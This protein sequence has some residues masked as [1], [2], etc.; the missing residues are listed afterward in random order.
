[1][2]S[3]IENVKI[4]IQMLLIGA[5]LLYLGFSI[6]MPQMNMDIFQFRPFVVRTESM[7]PEIMVNDLVVSTQFD[8][9]TA[10]PGDI[11]TFYADIDYNGTD[12]II[13]HYIY[14][15]DTSGEVPILRTHR[16]F[17]EEAEISPDTW[18]IPANEVLGTYG[19]HIPYIGYLISF[20]KSIYGMVVI[21]G[22]VVII[23]TIK[24]LK[25]RQE[26]EDTETETEKALREAQE[27]LQR[28]RETKLNQE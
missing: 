21:G 8:I 27:E 9:N 5:I 1:M 13:T 4:G 16:H 18:L 15:I 19:F 12:E 14:D 11:I 3:I 24:I 7:E 17:D 2:K 28:L 20:V 26:K 23:I 22:N 25:N 10:Q 6:F